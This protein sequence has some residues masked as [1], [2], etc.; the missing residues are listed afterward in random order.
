MDPKGVF[1]AILAALIYSVFIPVLAVLQSGRSEL[2]VARAM[3]IGAG[4]VFLLW[5]IP[6]GAMLDSLTPVS[7]AASA[8]QGVLSCVAFLAF[9][10]GLRHLGS[11]RSA[12]TSTAEP[13]WTTMLGAFV[14]SQ[15]PGA[16]TMI[17]GCAIVIAVLLLQIGPHPVRNGLT[18]STANV[19]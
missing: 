5:A 19:E 10:S 6:T 2:D 8:G 4:I 12:I 9:L 11:V 3:S 15:P 14:L 7:F 18:S 17:G 1:F 16:G 13:F